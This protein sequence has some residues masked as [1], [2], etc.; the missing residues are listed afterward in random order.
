MNDSHATAFAAAASQ[1]LLA[2]FGVDYYAMLWAFF[3]SL[4]ALSQSQQMGRSRAL[5]YVLLSTMAGAALGTVFIDWADSTRRG[6]L[7]FG[8]LVGGFGAQYIISALLQGVLNRIKS[9]GGPHDPTA[10]PPA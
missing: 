5:V 3:G 4:L 10:P 1:V 2:L 7:I 9:L 8:S 6:Y